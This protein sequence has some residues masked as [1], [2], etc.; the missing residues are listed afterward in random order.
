MLDR[1]GS[2]IIAGIGVDCGYFTLGCT[3]CWLDW[4]V[5]NKNAI[6]DW[7]TLFSTIFLLVTLTYRFGRSVILP[8][9]LCVSHS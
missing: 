8:F 3:Q 7:I 5:G 4:I 6:Y 2:W 9:L 1:E